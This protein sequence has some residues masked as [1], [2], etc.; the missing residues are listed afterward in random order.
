MP[1]TRPEDGQART[2]ATKPIKE[3]AD[4]MGVVAAALAMTL[5]LLLLAAALSALWDGTKRSGSPNTPARQLDP[6]R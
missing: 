1:R 5:N 3:S 6:T 4:A 2:E